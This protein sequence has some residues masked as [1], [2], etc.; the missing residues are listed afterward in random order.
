[1]RMF[2]KPIDETFRDFNI[3]TDTF[4]KYY[5]KMLASPIHTGKV[6][7]LFRYCVRKDTYSGRYLEKE[8]AHSPLSEVRN[9]HKL[10]LEKYWHES[11]TNGGRGFLAT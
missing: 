11:K 6:L 8:S 1:M 2:D 7:D 3:R 4:G 9:L 5:D 10:V